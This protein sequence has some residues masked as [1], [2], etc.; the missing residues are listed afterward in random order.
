MYLSIIEA[1]PKDHSTFFRLHGGQA[2]E[3]NIRHK[4]HHHPKHRNMHPSLQHALL[5][6]WQ[7]P[8]TT[9]TVIQLSKSF[10]AT[11]G[12]ASSSLRYCEETSRTLIPDVTSWD[13]RQISSKIFWDSTAIAMQTLFRH[14][15]RV[16]IETVCRDTFDESIDSSERVLPSRYSLLLSSRRKGQFNYECYSSSDLGNKNFSH[17]SPSQLTRINFRV[18]RLFLSTLSTHRTEPTV[19]A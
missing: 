6:E 14:Y 19:R 8:L 13:T 2:L 12:E 1:G 11:L 7:R 3:F 15:F 5:G 10:L 4:Q 18:Q 16:E 17:R 9:I